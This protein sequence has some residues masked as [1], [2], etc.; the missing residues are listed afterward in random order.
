MASADSQPP[1]A[2]VSVDID[3]ETHRMAALQSAVT[4]AQKQRK[5]AEETKLESE[6]KL[7]DA[8]KQRAEETQSIV[9]E[10][11]QRRLAALSSSSSSKC[12]PNL[13]LTEAGEYASLMEKYGHKIRVALPALPGLD[14]SSVANVSE[15]ASMPLPRKPRVPKSRHPS[16]DNLKAFRRRIRDIR[17]KK[18][19]SEDQDSTSNAELTIGQKTQ[20]TPLA[21]A[22]PSSAQATSPTTSLPPV[23]EHSRSLMP[24]KESLRRKQKALLK[25]T[26]VVFYR[27][28]MKEHM[29][30]I[31]AAVELTF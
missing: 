9:R 16:T 19:Q 26:P 24:K 28:Q 25:K 11:R 22:A 14:S 4:E 17:Q 31:L 21:P 7:A 3:F 6:R 13:E 1:K 30:K 27:P 10:D 18:Q 8:W 15:Q 29:E 23:P 5:I 12:P 2:D 20:R